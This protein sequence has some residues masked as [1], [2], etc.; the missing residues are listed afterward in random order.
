MMYLSTKWKIKMFQSALLVVQRIFNWSRKEPNECVIL[1]HCVY[2][3]KRVDQK[4][5]FRLTMMD[6]TLYG[7]KSW[8]WDKKVQITT[9][10]VPNMESILWIITTP[11]YYGPSLSHF[12][13]SRSREF[14]SKI[15]SCL[16]L[17]L[18]VWVVFG[19]NFN[20]V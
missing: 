13:F 6:Y 18:V 11:Y 2:P 19:V 7:W 16:G 15:F 17:F 9:I 20:Q 4:N 14:R 1:S 12:S 5:N 8:I 10:L 3:W